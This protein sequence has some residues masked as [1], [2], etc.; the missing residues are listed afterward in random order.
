[1][2]LRRLAGSPRHRRALFRAV[3]SPL[4]VLLALAGAAPA[5]GACP[6]P[7]AT[8]DGWAVADPGSRGLDPAPLCAL[9]DALEKRPDARPHGVVVVHR[10]TL[11]H[12]RYF[13]GPD[14]RWPQQHWGEALESTPHDAH[15]LH[16]VQSVTKSVV[17]ILAAIALERGLVAS[18]DAPVLS[19]F[20]E[21]ADLRD[22]RRDRITLRDLLTM[23]AGLDWPVRP[24]LA[25]A[26]S[27]D[28]AADPHRRVLA[29]P[30]TA[31]PGRR[32]QYN[33]GAAELVGGVVQRAA[34]R[35]LDAFAREVLFE[36]LGI[37]DWEW[38]R[39]ASGDPGASWGLRLKPRDLAKIGQL[40]LDEGVWRGRRIVSADGIREMVAPRV[41]RPR[42]SYAYLWWRER[43]T[44]DGRDV[45]WITASGWGGQCLAVAPGLALVVV[46][47]AGAYDWDGKGPQFETCE[48][49][50][51]AGARGAALLR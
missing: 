23:R 26:R 29:Q 8:D 20:P 32:W 50:M 48:A 44:A 15:S 37:V 12:E 5:S 31:E 10:G 36:P 9:D 14:R 22:P 27:V 18:V 49:A 25:M 2:S 21:Y 38:G 6:A 13:T 41:V 51:E 35:P 28:A 1:M 34:G 40:V 46:A 19:Y 4:V 24:Y 30:M 45:E 33:N 43:R 11:V 47:T 16:D 39:M 42:N 17:A 3:V 7:T